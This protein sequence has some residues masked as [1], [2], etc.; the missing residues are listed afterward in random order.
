MLQKIRQELLFNISSAE[1]T[2]PF[3]APEIR[4]SIALF[5]GFQNSP[6][7]PSDESIMNMKM[8]IR[9]WCKILT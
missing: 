3:S 8:N 5:D 9:N 6:S 2:I 4:K 1:G 7:C